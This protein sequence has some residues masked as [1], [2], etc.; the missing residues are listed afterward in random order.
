MHSNCS[1]YYYGACFARGGL[2]RFRS[3]GPGLTDGFA[4][5]TAT[6]GTAPYTYLWSNMSTTSTITGIGVGIYTVTVTDANGCTSSCE[7]ALNESPSFDLALRKVLAS[8]GPFGAGSNV[9]FNITVYNQGNLDGTNIQVTDYIPTGMSLNDANWTAVGS[10]ATLNTPIASLLSG[11]STTVSITLQIDANFAGTELVNYAEIS[12]ATNAMG[13]PDEDSSPDDNNTN[14]AGGQPDSPADNTVTGNGTGTPGDDVASTDEDDHDPALIN[15]EIFD[16]ALTKV[17]TTTGAVYPNSDVTFA[18]T[19]YN[20]GTLDATNVQVTDYIPAGMTL[21]DANW[22]AAGSLATLNTT[23]ASL[24]IGDSVVVNITL[25]IDANFSGTELVNYAE[26]S[27]SDNALNLS[28]IDSP[29][30]QDNTNDAGGQPNS[31]ADNE[32]MGDGTG[33]PGDGV[34]STDEDNQDPAL[35]TVTPLAIGSLGN[36][37]WYDDNQ[38]GLQDEPAANGINGLTVYL[39]D[40]SGNLLDSTVTAND[41]NGNPGYY[42][43]DSLQS[44][45]YY[46]Q[47]PLNAPNAIGLTGVVDQSP[48]VDGNNDA[49]GV[50]QSGLVVINTASTGLD[51]N[52]PTIDAGYVPQIFDLALRKTTAQVTPVNIGD[53]VVFTITVFNQGNVAAYDVDVQDAIP[54]G[55]TFNA[56]ASPLWTASGANAVANIAGPLAAGDSISLDITLT[57]ASGASSSNMTNIAEITAADN[58]QDSTNTPPTDVDSQPD[59]DPNNDTTVDDEINNGGGDEDDNDPATVPL[60]NVLGSLGNYLWYDDN[61]NGL[62]DEPAANGING[63]TVYLYDGSGNLLD[64]T[65]TAND[66]NGNPGYYTFDSLQSGTY[67]VQFP[68]NAPNAIGLTGVVDQSPQ[69]D[70]NN[71]ANNLGQ[72][73]IVTINTASTGL[74][75][76]NPT[77]DAGYVPQIFDL[78]LRK[79][80]STGNT[81]KYWR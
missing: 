46:V 25:K 9:T 59:T 8:A 41:V 54:A 29:E 26:I 35:V 81:S 58:D 30:D 53:D 14:D 38:N 45:T 28:D 4:Q 10:T 49:N 47:F 21:N 50:G 61:Q 62:Q 16:L 79:N 36:Y 77:I 18:I 33:A 32:V 39:Y 42:T 67:Y 17:L 6:G 31:P 73:G 5:V 65:V 68:L 51:V 72:S 11:D 52:N 43:F 34:A 20:Q 64:S 1:G 55:F 76:N 27:S 69:V 13:V 2:C 22:T 70:G 80:N 60:N 19:V 63:L 3:F 57:V 66:V 12:A 40:G 78:A 75:V 24:P 48:Q 15:V 71:D 37:L 44:G 23:I 56:G 7:V 74:D